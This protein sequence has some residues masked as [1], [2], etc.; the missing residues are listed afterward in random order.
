M[1]RQTDDTRVWY[2]WI[3][4]AYTWVGPNR[5]VKTGSSELHSSRKIACLMQ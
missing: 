2:E 4:E 1:W 3:V 5:R